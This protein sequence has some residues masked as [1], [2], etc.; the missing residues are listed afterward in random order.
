MWGAL[1]PHIY[2]FPCTDFTTQQVATRHT[3][4]HRDGLLSWLR[5]KRVMLEHLA[6]LR[7]PV[8]TTVSAH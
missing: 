3:I 4:T 1:D 2:H 6:R 5:H 7:V 8:C